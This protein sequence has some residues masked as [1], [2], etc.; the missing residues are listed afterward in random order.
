MLWVM[1]DKKPC[2]FIFKIDLIFESFE[3]LFYFIYMDEVLS[4]N[5]PY[6]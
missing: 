4:L 1:S 5:F 6:S 2:R 3:A